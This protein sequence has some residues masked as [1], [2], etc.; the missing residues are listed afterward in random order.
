L[1]K[2]SR[3]S[4]S[5]HALFDH[6]VRVEKCVFL[7]SCRERNVSALSIRIKIMFLGARSMPMYLCFRHAFFVKLQWCAKLGFAM[8][9]KCM[10]YRIRLVG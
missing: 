3:V 1:R 5:F 7:Y 6:T 2:A 9:M 10:K 4:S 8:E